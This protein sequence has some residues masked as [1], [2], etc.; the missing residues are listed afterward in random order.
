VFVQ[1]VDLV[2]FVA[3][4]GRAVGIKPRCGRRYNGDCHRD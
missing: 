2:E 1:L 4:V 3:T